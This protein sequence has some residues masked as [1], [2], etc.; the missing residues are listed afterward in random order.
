MAVLNYLHQ[1]NFVSVVFRLVLAMAACGTIGYG[2]TKRSKTAGFRTY[3]LTG[4]GAAMSIMLALYD[5][6]MM[7]TLWADTVST[8]GLKFDASRFSA[9]VIG[10]IGFIAAGSIISTAHHQVKGLT[11]A[12]GLFASV[13]MGFACGAGY[14]ECVILSCILIVLALNVMQPLERKY[15]RRWRNITLFV[16]FE[17]L[18][19][20]DDI[21]KVIKNNGATV[22]EIEIEQLERKGDVL[23]SAILNLR[24]GTEN[25]SHSDMMSSIAELD[26]VNSIEE[27]IS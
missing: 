19:N 22:Q 15:K 4:I 6:Q 25:P 7:N 24:L 12:T 26:C 1:F 18:R 10:G 9:A 11:T 23:P 13:C 5:Y 17:D 2:R 8:V 3:M 16:E 21:T 14:Y 20:I 27:L